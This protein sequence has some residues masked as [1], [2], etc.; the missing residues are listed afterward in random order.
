ML[1]VYTSN[2]EENVKKILFLNNTCIHMKIY[3]DIYGMYVCLC[4]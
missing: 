2:A 3:T 1:M 4:M